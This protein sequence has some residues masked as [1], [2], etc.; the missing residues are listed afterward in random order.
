MWPAN[1]SEGPSAAVIGLQ[2]VVIMF[3]SLP[4]C[5]CPTLSQVKNFGR[6][7]QTKWTHLA[8]EDTTQWDSA[9]AQET[10]VAAKM[11]HKMSGVGNIDAAFKRRKK[12]KE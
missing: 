11:Q 8:N 9:W 10:H 3:W 12:N 6:S 2:T 4:S 1:H 7:G 5:A